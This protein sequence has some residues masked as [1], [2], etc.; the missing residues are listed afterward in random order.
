MSDTR[1]RAR[2][3]IKTRIRQSDYDAVKEEARREHRSVS[4]QVALIV[5]RWVKEGA[6][7]N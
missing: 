7:D 4:A 3:A 5:E 1:V 6:S 2:P